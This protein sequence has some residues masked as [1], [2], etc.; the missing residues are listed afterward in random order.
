M[1]DLTQAERVERFIRA[2]PGSTTM[3]I[4]LGCDPFISNPRARISDLRAK[5]IDVVCEKRP[6]GRD[7]FRIRERRPVLTG[8]QQALAL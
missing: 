1:T 3:Q 2:N 7:G 8:E 6:D 4:Q 5:G